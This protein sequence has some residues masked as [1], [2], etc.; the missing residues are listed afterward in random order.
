MS[1]QKM[2]LT[3]FSSRNAAVQDLADR[4]AKTSSKEA[5]ELWKH[6]WQRFKIK[7]SQFIELPKCFPKNNPNSPEKVRAWRIRYQALAIKHFL[8]FF[9]SRVEY[10]TGKAKKRYE[11]VIN[12]L[13][14]WK[15]ISPE[16]IW[17]ES[18]IPKECIKLPMPEP[19]STLL[20]PRPPFKSSC[21]ISSQVGPQENLD[22]T[23]HCTGVRADR[24]FDCSSEDE[25][26]EFVYDLAKYN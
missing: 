9:R 11:N 22:R 16:H 25:I 10:A 14:S 15:A 19:K 21:N 1:D 3:F 24:E 20:L 13:K 8:P 23:T 26:L 2:Q 5:S 17:K 6:A 12:L 7:S 4:C 18:I